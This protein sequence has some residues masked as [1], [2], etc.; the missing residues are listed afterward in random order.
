M[1]TASA[2]KEGG[3]ERNLERGQVVVEALALLEEV[4][5]GGLTLRK[6]ADRLHVKAAALYWHFEN[7]Q[8]LIDAMAASI[9]LGAFE[10][11]TPPSE[12]WRDLLAW[13]ARTNHQALLSR[14]DGVQILAHANMS[15]TGMMDGLEALMRTLTQQGFSSDLAMSSFFAIIRYT[16]GCVF[17]EQADPRHN[18]VGRNVERV[19]RLQRNP[20]RYPYM[21]KIITPII[22]KQRDNPQFL[23]EQGLDIILDGVGKRF[24]SEKPLAG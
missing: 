6:L 20:E 4:G 18:S 2:A 5:V 17:E 24:A 3:R 23:F 9:I 7:K 13:I 22:K 12:N 19:H 21:N 1:T 15:Q 8:D 16:I 10:R 14:R 11:S